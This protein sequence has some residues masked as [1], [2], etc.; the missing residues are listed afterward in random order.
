MNE[1]SNLIVFILG[2]APDMIALLDDSAFRS[3]LAGKPLG[4]HKPGKTCADD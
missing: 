1:H 3:K 2:I 4:K